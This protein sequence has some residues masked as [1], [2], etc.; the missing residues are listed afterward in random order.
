MT[1][2]AF[3]GKW[4]ATTRRSDFWNA[5]NGVSKV[6]LQKLNEFAMNRAEGTFDAR[7]KSRVRPFLEASGFVERIA[8]AMLQ[9]DDFCTFGACSRIAPKCK[10]PKS[11]C[12]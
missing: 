12:G 2:C 6:Q 8:K 11:R 5:G 10:S 4:T 1:M 3:C 9:L 7:F